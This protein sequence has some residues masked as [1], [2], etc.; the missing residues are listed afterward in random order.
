[1]LSAGFFNNLHLIKVVG[2][3]SVSVNFFIFFLHNVRIY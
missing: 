3:A 2:A 1:M